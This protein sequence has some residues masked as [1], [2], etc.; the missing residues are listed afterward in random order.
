MCRPPSSKRQK[1]YERAL[2]GV[3][4]IMDSPRAAILQLLHA[5]RALR[6]A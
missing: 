6:M 5:L 4:A 1:S 2:F 3:H